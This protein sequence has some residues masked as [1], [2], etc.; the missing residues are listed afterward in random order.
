MRIKH[1]LQTAN[2]NIPL[3]IA[4]IYEQ[5]IDNHSN[6]T[7]SIEN[8]NTTAIVL[9]WYQYK[10]WYGQRNKLIDHLGF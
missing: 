9:V 5:T 10:P 2:E 4:G 1:V 8:E 6:V 7:P 3:W